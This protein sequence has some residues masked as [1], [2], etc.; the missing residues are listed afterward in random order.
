MGPRSRLLVL[1]GSLVL[2][3]VV[4]ATALFVFSRPA[5]DADVATREAERVSVGAPAFAVAADAEA[6]AAAPEA[7]AVER[8]PQPAP[9]HE[10]RAAAADPTLADAIWIDG[11]LAFP[12]GTPADER[13]RVT[14]RG[15]KFRE[16]DE[17][18]HTVDVA[19][20]GS[21]RAAFAPRT[22]RGWFRV[23][24]RYVRLAEGG[25]FRLDEI[26]QPVA[27]AGELG[28]RIEGRIVPPAH[29][30]PE[31]RAALVGAQVH[32]RCDADV[33]M[34]VPRLAVV[35]EELRFAFDALPAGTTHYVQF[36]APAFV[37]VASEA[38]VAAG[39]TAELELELQT[40]VRV[41][42]RV[43]DPDGA[44]I[45]G[46]RVTSNWAMREAETDADG[47]FE[48]GGIE[49]G[50][51]GLY[52]EARGMAP[53]LAELGELSDRARIDDH[54]I[55]LGDGLA[56]RGV[57]RWP[58]GAPATGALVVATKRMDA[59]ADDE[60]WL[61]FAEIETDSDAEGR[62]ALLGLGPSRFDVVATHA[63]RAEDAE[64]GSAD[65]TAR[66]D[67]VA[68]GR[69]LVLTLGAGLAMRGRVVDERGRPVERFFVEARP[70]DA[71]DPFYE[72]GEH[73]HE[74]RSKDG[75]FEL[76]RLYAGR[77]RVAAGAPGRAPSRWQLVELPGGGDGLVLTV[78]SKA[79]IAGRV[80]DQAGEPV[81]RAR[82]SI[83]GIHAWEG[84][85]NAYDGSETDRAD[86]DGTFQRSVVPGAY[87]LTARAPGLVATDP[88]AVRVDVGEQVEDVVLRVGP[89]GA[90]EGTALRSDGASAAGQSVMLD[91][92]DGEA[93]AQETLAADGSFRFGDLAPGRY[94]VQL[95]PGDDE[96]AALF[97]LDGAA[98][99]EALRAMRQSRVVSVAAGATA[100]VDLGGG[101]ST[102][103]RLE[104]T[105]R[106]A[107]EPLAGAS[108]WVGRV[109]GAAVQGTTAADA[110][111][112]FEID[113]DAPGEHVIHVTY[114]GSAA[115]RPV[116]VPAADVHRVDFDF[117]AGTV[118]GKVSDASGRGLANVHVW[119]VRD[120]LGATGGAAGATGQDGTWSIGS[121]PAGRYVVYAGGLGAHESVPPYPLEARAGVVV[122]TGETTSGVE[123]VLG[124]AA[125]VTGRIVDE[126]G[127][128]VE[129]GGVRVRSVDGRLLTNWRATTDA[130]G[131]F[132]IE[133]LGAG[134]HVLV[135][136]TSGG[137]S[138]EG[139]RV[140]LRAG[141]TTEV[142]LVV[143]QAA[144]LEV[145]GR[146]GEDRP[147]AMT[148]HVADE[149]G[150]DWSLNELMW[151]EPEWSNADVRSEQR[152]GPL[153]PGRYVVSGRDGSGRV[154]E[155]RVTLDDA[156]EARVVLRFDGGR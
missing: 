149:R 20:D 30:S 51:V 116:R 151:S 137:V 154:V 38:D 84:N 91:R 34:V 63:P 131:R 147:V 89:A 69:E 107:G 110:D 118:A 83:D 92:L 95:M 105:V 101:V 36:D 76:P 35:D 45:E 146:D 39:E 124:A 10:R 50:P 41:A 111:G 130:E 82:V 135:A 31:D 108:V 32:A 55:V 93:W 22:R 28:G 85:P 9:E 3:G 12:E 80:V 37:P 62:F 70:E 109:D 104:G 138:S 68:A 15:A 72:E 121:V 47:R 100:R 27:L 57:V 65:W 132:R 23:E 145:R 119:V 40:G 73:S 125:P 150:C 98:G 88:V 64:R 17:R 153:P 59:A 99:W 18:E 46:V 16:R 66:L 90:I 134:E 4:L 26:E 33:S 60:D 25:S 56:L 29:A 19:A 42:G 52:A 112:A 24:A 1:L 114:G 140:E 113:L 122:R 143:R 94:E 139:R 102:R 54:E 2:G 61:P 7:R 141:V 78:S 44:P 129:S 77:W 133:D 11:V 6:T 126:R 58:D 5:P 123:L 97:E 49:P 75:A 144:W 156:P 148:V 87:R 8:E 86:D 128:P 106:S 155:R 136:V 115:W 142:E 120:G 152:Y 53:V 74:F 81:P 43:V 79:S 103:V 14:A 67:D 71:D 127:M 13:V 96:T 117:A 48:L 21:F